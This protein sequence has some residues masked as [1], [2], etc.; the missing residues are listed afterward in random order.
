MDQIYAKEA[1]ERFDV[2]FDGCHEHPIDIDFTLP[3]YCSD[4]Q[5]ILKCR[6]SPEISSYSV[7]QDT[8]V[9]DGTCVIHVYYLDTHGDAV[10]S[11]EAR[12]QFSLQIKLKHSVTDPCVSLR[13]KCD[14]INCRAVSARRVDIHGAFSVSA[15]VTEKRGEALLDTTGGEDIE[16]LKEPVSISTARAQCCSQFTVE[17]SQELPAGKPP[18]ETILRSACTV[19]MDE[20]R[21]VEGK[22]LVK[23][24]L[25]VCVLYLSAADGVTLEPMTFEI[26]FSRLEDCPGLT[27]DAVLDLRLDA[28]EVTVSPKAEATGENTRLDIWVRLF[29]YGAAYCEESIEFVTDA[30]STRCPVALEHAQGTFVSGVSFRRERFSKKVRFEIAGHEVS[31]ITD[32]WAESGS[33]NAFTDDSGLHGKGRYTLCVLGVDLSGTPFYAEQAVEFSETL[34]DAGMGKGVRVSADLELPRVSAYRNEA[35][36]ALEVSVELTICFRL[37]QTQNMT[38]I[39]AVETEYDKAYPENNAAL[40]VYFAQAGER[41]W[42]I[43]KSHRAGVSALREENDCYEDTI[44]EARTLLIPV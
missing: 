26:P 20:T 18:V 38:Y 14:Y 6:F 31:S 15:F 34:A 33:V 8:L 2:L 27:E 42:N 32:V 1:F 10:H 12:Q 25:N 44:E 39:S 3:D 11:C 13:A 7:M 23:G 19:R 24:M 40:A 5:K 28:G 9:C 29:L 17:D 4:I 37:S 22:L 16:F 30:Y 36:D 21:V 41:V 43:A 35:A